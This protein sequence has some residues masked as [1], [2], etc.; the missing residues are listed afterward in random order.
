MVQVYYYP[1]HP[2][3]TISSGDLK[4]YVGLKNI[5]FEHIEHCDFVDPQGCSWIS[6]YQNQNNLDYLQIKIVKVKPHINRNIFVPN[7]CALPKQNLYQLIHQNFGHV[8]ITRLKLMAIKGSWK[9]SQKISPNWKIPDLPVSGPMQLKLPEVQ[10]P[11][12]K[13]FPW[14]HASNIFFIF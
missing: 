8:S 7:V 11:M 9:V 6:P 4:F 14:V 10:S 13:N 12:S 2:S 5:T 3:N 1:G